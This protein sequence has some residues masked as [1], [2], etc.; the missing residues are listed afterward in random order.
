MSAVHG[1][2]FEMKKME[3]GTWRQQSDY[4]VFLDKDGFI[5]KCFKQDDR[6][7]KMYVL[8]VPLKREAFKQRLWNN[9]GLDFLAD[10]EYYDE[11]R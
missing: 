5:R 7:A 8:R 2:D 3:L 11:R 6:D 10:G 4:I 1:K 9:R